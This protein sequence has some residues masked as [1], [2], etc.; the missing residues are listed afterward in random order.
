MRIEVAGQSIDIGEVVYLVDPE[1]ARPTFHRLKQDGCASG[2]LWTA[3]GLPRGTAPAM[4]ADG[5][6]HGSVVRIPARHARRFA[7]PCLRCWPAIGRQAELELKGG[8]LR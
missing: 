3:C 8:P 4:D 2:G 5:A 6:L 7:R 1:P